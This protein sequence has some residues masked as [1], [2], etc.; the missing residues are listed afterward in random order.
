MTYIKNK[1][2]FDP[3]TDHSFIIKVLTNKYKKLVEKFGDV[4]YCEFNIASDLEILSLE[5]AVKD[6]NNPTFIKGKALMSLFENI[7]T[8]A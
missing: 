5:Y 6:F 1:V 7:M 4:L 2:Y 8:E 3:A